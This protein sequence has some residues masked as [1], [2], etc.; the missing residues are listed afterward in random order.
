MYSFIKKSDF[1]NYRELVQEI[2]DSDREEETLDDPMEIDFIKK[3]EPNTSIATIPVKIKRLK[4]SAIVIDS[5]AEPTIILKD[6][7]KRI[8]GKIDKSVIYD[9]SRATTIS[10]ESISITCNLPITFF[11]GF[12]I[13]KDYIVVK[14]PKPILLFPNPHLKKYKCTMDWD[15]DELKIPFNRKDH[16]IPV[17]MIKVKNKLE[18][19]CAT[20]TQGDKFLTSDQILQVTNRDEDNNELLEKWHALAGFSLD[21]DN[22]TL[23]KNV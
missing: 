12:I 17:T 5:R 13:H 3:E 15:K 10:T 8:G 9:F 2:P 18:V 19:N 16:I 4:I 1:T 7:V 14:T 22:S 21:S 23:K 6:I 20:I 11:P